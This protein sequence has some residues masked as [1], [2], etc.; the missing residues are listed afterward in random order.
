MTSFLISLG[1]IYWGF[2]LTLASYEM[3]PRESQNNVVLQN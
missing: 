2:T 1:F 3:R